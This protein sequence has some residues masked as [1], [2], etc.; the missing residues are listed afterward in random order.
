[1]IYVIFKVTFDNLGQTEHRE[2][3]GYS[4]DETEAHTVISMLAEQGSMDLYDV[5]PV[6]QCRE[7]LG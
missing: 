5:E 4:Q 1:M 3:I 7:L 2:P 6:D